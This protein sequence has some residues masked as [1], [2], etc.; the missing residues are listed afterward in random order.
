MTSASRPACSSASWSRKMFPTDFAIFSPSSRTIPLCIQMRASGLPRAASVW[1][2]SFSWCGK[3]RSE[4]PPWIS[5]STP[6][7]LLG[8][9]RALDVPA[10]AGHGPRARPRRCPR[11]PSAPSRARSPAGSPSARRRRRPRPAASRR[12]G[13]SRACRTPGSS[14]RGSRRRPRPRRRAPTRSGRAISAMIASIVPVAVGSRSGRPEPEAV[15]VAHV[16][17]RH[18]A[19]ELLAPDAGLARRVVDLVVHVGDVR[20]ERDVVALVLEEALEQREDDERARVA[21]RGR[22]RRRWGRTR[23][24][25]PSRLARLE[26]AARSPV[27]V[28]WI[29]INPRAPR[30]PRRARPCPRRGPRTPCPR[31][32]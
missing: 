18:L 2:I 26:L 30:S 31:S 9:R 29:R 6:E 23:R 12:A 28:S 15:R 20:D 16:V 25:R 5:K 1:A 32:S 11:P 4:P 14:R 13:G 19:G 8:H 22:G 24:C 27:S 21:R 10:R 7:D 17:R 3:T